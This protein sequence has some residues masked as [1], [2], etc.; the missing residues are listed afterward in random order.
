MERWTCSHQAQSRRADREAGS[1]LVPIPRLQPVSL[2]LYRLRLFY[3]RF[4]LWGGVFAPY[5]KLHSQMV[6]SPPS[7]KRVKPASVWMVNYPGQ[8]ATSG[9]ICLSASLNA[10]S[11]TAPALLK[12]KEWRHGRHAFCCGYP[13]LISGRKVSWPP[14]V[15][16]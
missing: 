12:M 16:S 3:C 2:F 15:S 14:G 4:Q 13:R 5:H 11:T 1:F 9:I 10:T 6:P 7:I 8:Y